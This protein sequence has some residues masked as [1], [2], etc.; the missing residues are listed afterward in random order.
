MDGEIAQIGELK[1]VSDGDGSRAGDENMEHGRAGASAE[2][3]SDETDVS[4]K[5]IEVV[6]ES[7]EVARKGLILQKLV[8]VRMPLCIGVVE[9]SPGPSSLG[10]EKN[11]SVKW[12][13]IELVHRAAALS[14]A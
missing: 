2:S 9:N 7:E 1:R 6:G 4:D 8:K 11:L 14:S 12:D 3:L 13:F 10:L 5:S